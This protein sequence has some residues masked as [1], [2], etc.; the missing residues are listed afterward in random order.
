MQINLT[1]KQLIVLKKILPSCTL[2]ASDIQIFKEIQEALDNP[3]DDRNSDNRDYSKKK[4]KSRNH[5]VEKEKI[6]KQNS[7]NNDFTFTE[8]F[9]NEETDNTTNNE[10]KEHEHE[11]VAK[12]KE[13]DNDTANNKHEE[14]SKV[15]DAA[16]KYKT[17]KPNLNTDNGLS[18]KKVKNRE[19]SSAPTIDELENAGPFG[20]IDRRFK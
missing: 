7:S 12:T 16:E 9:E 14:V 3:I 1:P 19:D 2:R 15:K 17:S 8:D 5:N 6:E 13:M 10:N 20:E 11:E 18:R 4:V